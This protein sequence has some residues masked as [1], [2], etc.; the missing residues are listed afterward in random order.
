MTGAGSGLG[1]A[2]ARALLDD[3][4]AV[5]LAG[6]T[7][8]SLEETARTVPAPTRSRTDVTSASPVRALFASALALHGRVDVLVNN[9]GIFGPGGAVDEVGDADWHDVLAAKRHRLLPLRA[10]GGA[11]HEGAAAARRQDHQQRLAVGAFS[12]CAG[13]MSSTTSTRGPPR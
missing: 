5:V 6:R 9:A 1:R 2:V 11:H 13:A 10:R 4:H 7:K 12:T 3:G 8:A